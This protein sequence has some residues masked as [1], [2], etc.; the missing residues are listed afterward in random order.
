[1]TGPSDHFTVNPPPASGGSYTFTGSVP[2]PHQSHRC[3]LD[4]T[5]TRPTCRVRLRK[6]PLTQLLMGLAVGDPV[7]TPVLPQS[8]PC[9]YV[10][11]S[12][13][14]LVPQCGQVLPARKY[15]EGCHFECHL[16]GAC[17][18]FPLAVG[19]LSHQIGQRFGELV[20]KHV[21]WVLCTGAGDRAEGPRK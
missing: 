20:N 16:W 21:W 6:G 15:L 18:P 19:L 11:I 9:W 4:I 5:P 12:K 3:R 17:L 8:P 2:S 13:D 1:M 10:Q 14:F 7:Q